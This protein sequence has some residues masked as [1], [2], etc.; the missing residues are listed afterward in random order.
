[1]SSDK[2]PEI[3]RIAILEEQYDQLN[4]FSDEHHILLGDIRNQL[5]ALNATINNGL[6][7][8]LENVKET[9]AEISITQAKHGATLKILSWLGGV[10][11]TGVAGV[12]LKT[13]AGS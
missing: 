5:A 2:L 11:I 3:T 1:M 12:L 10:V 6:S 13:L 4:K 7:E 9:Q 8:T